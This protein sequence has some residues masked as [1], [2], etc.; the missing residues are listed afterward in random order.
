MLE[1]NGL[2]TEQRN[3]K[4]MGLDLMSP[5]EIVTIMNEEDNQVVAAVH[6]Q[7]DQIAKAVELVID[8]FERG[9]RLIY[10]G[11]GTSGRLGVLDAVE[12]VPT[13]G[14]DENMV[15]GLIAGGDKAFVRAVEG[16]E[17][18]QE[19]A[20]E[21]LK[22]L[23]LCDRDVVV[24]IAAS[25]RTPY[26]IGGLLYAG[27]VGCKRVSIACCHHSKAAE[28]AD[29]AIEAVAG[30]EVLTGSTRLK[31]GSCQKMI[32]NMISTASMVGIGK[33]YQNLMVDVLQTN[34]KLQVRAQNIV[35]QATGVTREM[36]A[37]MLK[38]CDGNA[39]TAIVAILL[40]C[41]P[42]TARNNLKKASGRVRLA[43]ENSERE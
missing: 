5:K 10:M 4:T 36:A 41:D 12:C 40:R 38:D 18:S 11:A 1:L 6:S 43:V 32:L 13:F 9:G 23:S 34:E 25:G 28:F 33:T 15:I 42:D 39:K 35:M 2:S 27:D 17:D 14:V 22:E 21:D 7:L 24:G 30:P 29:V 19:L 26:V 3:E 37:A 31:S 20:R 8:A 16:S